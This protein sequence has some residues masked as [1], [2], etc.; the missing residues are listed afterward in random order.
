[1]FYK[2]VVV[3]IPDERT[4]KALKHKTVDDGLTLNALML[5]LI[6][7][8]LNGDSKKPIS[9]KTQARQGGAPEA[10]EAGKEAE[11]EFW[12]KEAKDLDTAMPRFGRPRK[13]PIIP[14]VE[15]RIR[16]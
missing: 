4:Y 10:T 8:Y 3:Y 13:G 6:R 1:M 7:Q 12:D 16:T 9:T 5:K 11:A 2:R 15:T 14:P